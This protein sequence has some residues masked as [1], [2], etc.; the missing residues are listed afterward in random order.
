[1]ETTRHQRK[2]VH[3]N[4]YA[5]EVDVDLIINDDAWSPYLSLEDA[6]KLDN[7]RRALLRG[8]VVGASKLAKVFRLLPV[9][10]A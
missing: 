1:M 10:A 2:I 3:E 4:G 7:V 6:T 9:N 8:D 5:A